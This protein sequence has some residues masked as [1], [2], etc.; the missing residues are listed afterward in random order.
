MVG[1]NVKIGLQSGEMVV[2]YDYTTGRFLGAQNFGQFRAPRKEARLDRCCGCFRIP[3]NFGLSYM[4]TC[5]GAI[6]YGG[7]T[8]EMFTIK[9]IKYYRIYGLIFKSIFSDSGTLPFTDST[10][11]GP[12]SFVGYLTRRC[13][14]RDAAGEIYQNEFSVK[15]RQN[16]QTAQF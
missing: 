3:S 16:Q 2:G 8:L 1:E 15:N 11:R 13:Q 10:F 9:I 4:G 7:G 6:G 14:T 5:H 12:N